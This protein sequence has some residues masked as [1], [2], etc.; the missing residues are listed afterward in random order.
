MTIFAKQCNSNLSQ[1]LTRR[2]RLENTT[3]ADYI[4][5][6]ATSP[7]N[8]EDFMSA[9]PLTLPP[10]HRSPTEDPILVWPTLPSHYSDSSCGSSESNPCSPSDSVSSFLFSPT[11]DSSHP[12]APPLS[13]SSVSSNSH[14]NG[15]TAGLLNGHAAIRAAGKIGVRKQR[16]M[17]RNSWSPFS[18]SVQPRPVVIL[19]PIGVTPPILASAKD[20]IMES[21]PIKLETSKLS[22]L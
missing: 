17:N 10:S 18:T 4:S 7:R 2:E 12:S 19:Q 9:F 1:W 15:H 6:A 22:N 11:S 8:P 5:P 13:A 21:K 3:E 20:V 14:I 16:S